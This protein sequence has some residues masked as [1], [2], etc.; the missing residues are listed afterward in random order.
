MATPEQAANAAEIVQQNALIVQE[1][2]KLL[3][4]ILDAA[5]ADRTHAKQ[6]DG[7]SNK[8][9]VI[10]YECGNREVFTLAMDKAEARYKA[11]VKAR[12]INRLPKIWTQSKSDIKGMFDRGISFT[13]VNPET[14]IEGV[15]SFA[16]AKKALDKA[17]KDAAKT[18][19]KAALAEIPEDVQNLRAVVESIIGTGN[20]GL[21]HDV[22]VTVAEMLQEY[23]KEHPEQEKTDED[24]ETLKA[25]VG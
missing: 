2:E 22:A 24:D 6:R 15:M 7:I 14:G 19:E 17:R 20:M 11:S 25:A 21:V 16:K 18:A 13:E 1:T 3:P 10:A 9:L 23:R 4:L 12:G 8:L 5:K